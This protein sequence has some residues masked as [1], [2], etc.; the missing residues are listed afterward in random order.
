MTPPTDPVEA[1]RLTQATALAAFAN[2]ARSRILDALAVDGPSTASQLAHRVGMAVGSASHHLKVLAEAGLVE[3][4]PGLTEDRRQRHW[5]LAHAHTRWSRTEMTD[6][7]ARAAAY[8]AELVTLQ[9][10]FDRARDAVLA[11][12]GDHETDTGGFATQQW[13]TLSAAELRALSEELL[14]VLHRWQY[15]DLPDDGAERDTVFV[16]ARGFPAQP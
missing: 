12:E 4:A 2:P 3:E 14:A 5:R 9:R 8:E 11:T 1:H 6:P 10:Q 15:R 13:L 16:F 7:S